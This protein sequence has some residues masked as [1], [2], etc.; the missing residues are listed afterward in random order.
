MLMVLC[1]SLLCA[2]AQVSYTWSAGDIVTG[3]ITPT[4]TTFVSAIDRLDVVTGSDHDFASR[5]VTNNG[6]WSW[7]DGN[8]RGGG[9]NLTNNATFNDSAT[10]SITQTF[11]AWTFVNSPGATYAKSAGITSFLTPF[12]NAG[13]IAVT[14]GTLNLA[15]G[16]NFVGGAKIGSSGP[17]IVQLTGG[18]LTANGGILAQN[19]LLT[20]GQLTGFQ[21][22]DGTLNWVATNLNTTGTMTIASTGTLAISSAADHD[23]NGHGI[24]NNGIVN[25]TAGRIR[26]GTGG[27]IVNNG[28]WNDTASS[29][30]NND[31]LGAT[32]TFTNTSTGVYNKSTAG[33][34]NFLIP[35]NNSGLIKVSVG[36]LSLQAGFT[37]TNG[38]I[39]LAGGT[40]ASTTAITMGTGVL[41]GTGIVNTPAITSA[42]PIFPGLPAAAG[43][44]TINGNLSLL[45][46]AQ[47]TFELGGTAQGT[48]YDYLVIGG[49]LVLGGNLAL[50]FIGGFNTSVTGGMTFTLINSTTL[51]GTFLNVANGT[52]LTTTDGLGS[53]VVNYGAGSA[54]PINTV[55]LSNFLA[56]PEPSTWA[57][58]L[59][60][61]AFLALAARRRR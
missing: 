33:P 19:F 15:A 2:R 44:L 10:A 8:I 7:Y 51:A 56:V 18:I 6:V 22:F 59:T 60:G 57:L 58:L 43:L 20:G 37:N 36:L 46:T 45:S 1:L 49:N 3:T 54:F 53:F 21:T 30:F 29:D 11:G 47:P 14:N 9:G 55:V 17:G 24:V 48:Q 26:S 13:T 61:V 42:G 12:N 39:A 23:Y 16:G 34:T 5:N 28:A 31:Y 38:S 25:W 27:S 32:A 52:R 41:S 4:G 35:L 50:T 40:L